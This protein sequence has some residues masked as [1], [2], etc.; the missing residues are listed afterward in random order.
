MR[1]KSGLQFTR[2]ARPFD[3]ADRERLADELHAAGR[4]SVVYVRCVTGDRYDPEPLHPE[5]DLIVET[6]STSKARSVWANW[7]LSQEVEGAYR[8]EV[9]CPNALPAGRARRQRE[10]RFVADIDLDLMQLERE[11]AELDAADRA[12]GLCL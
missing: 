11:L 7:A 12:L 10:T 3:L 5:L 4:P 1:T 8:V 6:D 2:P 9:C